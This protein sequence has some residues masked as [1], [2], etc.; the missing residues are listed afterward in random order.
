MGMTWIIVGPNLP[1]L[2][3]RAD[4]FDEAIEMARVLDEEYCGGYVLA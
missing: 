2:R 3:I 1:D 4:S